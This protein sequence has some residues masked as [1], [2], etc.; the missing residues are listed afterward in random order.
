MKKLLT[1]AALMILSVGYAK[2]AQV[3]YLQDVQM[4]KN[5]KFGVNA[6]SANPYDATLI[7]KNA[8]SD[9][10]VTI[11]STEATSSYDLYLPKAAGSQ[12]QALTTD[13]NGQ[14]GW[15]TVSTATVNDAVSQSLQAIANSSHTNI[16]AAYTAPNTLNLSLSSS[17]IVDGQ[18]QEANLGV[19]HITSATV[20]GSLTSQSIVNQT[21]LQTG[22]IAST[23]SITSGGNIGVNVDQKVILNNSTGANSYIS[24]QSGDNSVEFFKNGV[25]YMRFED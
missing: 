8:A 1:I 7:L 9:N 21:S 24:Q 14:L 13:S 23:G 11:K 12:G 17:V 4:D 18:N 25:L 15:T 16:N 22:S 2:A 10:T 6:S 3:H 5:A 20:N 19:L